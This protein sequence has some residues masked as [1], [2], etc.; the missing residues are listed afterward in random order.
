MLEYMYITND[1]QIAKMIDELGVDRVWIDLEVLG[2][3]E[4]Q[5]NYDSVKS[6]HSI[7]DIQVIRPL[8]RQAKLQVRINPINPN[9]KEE[10]DKVIEAGCDYI[11]LPMFKTV[12]EVKTFFD[13]VDGRVKTILLFETKEAVEILEDIL[14]LDCI[15]EIH[16]GLNDLHLSMGKQFMFELLVDGT[17]EYICNKIKEKQI[18]YGF[19]GIA[20]IG[21]GALPAEYIIGEHYRMGSTRAILSRSFCNYEKIQN[22]QIFKKEFED[23]LRELKRYEQTLGKKDNVFF[24]ENNKKIKNIVA[25][26]VMQMEK[27]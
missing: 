15:D 4:R 25:E 13:C 20:R 24:E 18:P 6:K 3:E 1:P 2:K 7:Q 9:S 19:G 8:L 14:D 22:G 27:E 23:G 21:Q 11:M 5:K 17:V 16:I 12:D 10:I 26:I